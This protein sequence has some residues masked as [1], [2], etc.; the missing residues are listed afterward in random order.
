M[1]LTSHPTGRA[2]YADTRKWLLDEHGPICAYCGQKF[3]VKVMTLDHVA[4]RRGQTAF[5][6]RDNLVLACPA[7]NG[8]KR[9]MAPL[10]FLLGNRTRAVNLV[11]YGWHLSAGLIDMARALVPDAPPP[12]RPRLALS[13]LPALDDEEDPYA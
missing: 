12:G 8:I 6:R 13:D 7:C 4:P 9:D 2:A 10:A 1:H 11:K 5:D 3:P